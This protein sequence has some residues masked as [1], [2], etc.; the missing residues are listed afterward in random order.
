MRRRPNHEIE[1]SPMQVMIKIMPEMAAYVF[2]KC[3]TTNGSTKKYDYEF[4]DDTYFLP[5]ERGKT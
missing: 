2:D 1:N 5:D 4:L 3:V